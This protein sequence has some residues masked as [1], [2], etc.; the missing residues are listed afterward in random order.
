MTKT[1]P[2]LIALTLLGLLIVQWKDWP[3]HSSRGEGHEEP[4]VED[5]P[6]T[7]ADM[8]PLARLKAPA[9]RDNYLSIIERPLFRPDRK[10]EPPPDE[11]PEATTGAETGLELNTLDLSAVMITPTIVSA[12]VTDPS[13]PA[14]RRLRIGDDIEGWLVMDI[15]DDRVLFE[16]QGEEYALILRDYSK[17]PPTEAPTPIP[18]RP[19]RAP[20]SAEPKD[21]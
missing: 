13:Q 11:T 17:T 20:K 21:H 3:T 9:E 4:S 18:R 8:N 10:P 2:G 1:L 14:L 6:S 5:S 16:R 12:W 15:L 19:S 7:E